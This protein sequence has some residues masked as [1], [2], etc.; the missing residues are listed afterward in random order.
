VRRLLHAL[1]FMTVFGS[2]AAA[3]A[4]EPD[5]SGQWTM[6]ASK[7]DYGQ[8]PLP[9]SFTRKIEHA[10]PSITIVEEQTGPNTTPTSTRK[11]KT[12]GVTTADNINGGEVK[13]SATWEG[14]TLIAITTIDSFGVTFKDKMT[15]SDDSKMLTSVVEIESAQGNAT[16]TIVFDR[17]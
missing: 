12:D 8:L 17:Q 1:M 3:A 6:N 13:M 7:S 11:M 14:A 2:A 10:E 9:Q 5:F 4:A 15:L 16:L